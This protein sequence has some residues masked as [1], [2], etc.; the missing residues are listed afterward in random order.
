MYGGSNCAVSKPER[1]WLILTVPLAALNF[2]AAGL[3]LGNDAG[4]RGRDPSAPPCS[5]PCARPATTDVAAGADALLG[6][7]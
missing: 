4:R 3:A 2:Y 6:L 7:P 1:L 5:A